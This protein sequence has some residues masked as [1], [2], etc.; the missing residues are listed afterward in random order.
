MLTL[1]QGKK[2][3]TTDT[4]VGGTNECDLMPSS[5]QYS[6][7]ETDLANE[8]PILVQDKRIRIALLSASPFMD[9][10]SSLPRKVTWDLE[11]L[12]LEEATIS[13]SCQGQTYLSH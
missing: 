4:T 7:T 13:V 11:R 9:A 10:C 2:W 6:R 1:A 5:E 3:L 12:M 8:T